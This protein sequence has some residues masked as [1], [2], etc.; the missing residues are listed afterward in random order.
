MPKDL[1]AKKA[2]AYSLFFSF[3]T[4]TQIIKKVKVSSTTLNTWVQKW[5]VE[6]SKVTTALIEEARDRNQ[7]DILD[8]FHLG[9]PLIKSSL[10]ARIKEDKPLD[11]K[12]AQQVTQILMDFDKLQRLEIGK[13]TEIHSWLKPASIDDLKKA[14]ERDEFIDVTELQNQPKSHS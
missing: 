3:E 12:E 7:K 6:R 9:L 11:I 13:P 10:A 14:L 1:E 5:K 2:Q 8:I 4:P